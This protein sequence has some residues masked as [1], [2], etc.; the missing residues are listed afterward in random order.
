MRFK[1]KILIV[2][3]L[4]FLS[5][6]APA[7]KRVEASLSATLVSKFMWRGVEDGNA[8]IQPE[9][10]VAWRGFYI[11]L[12]G[13]HGLMN[14]T[15]ENWAVNELDVNIGWEYKGLT[16]GL[17]DEFITW[18][19]SPPKYFYFKQGGN[20]VLEATI[21]YDWGF[22]AAQWYTNIS[23][24]PECYEDE[25]GRLRHAY[26]SYLE[27]SAPFRLGGLDW[28]ALVGIVPYN[29]HD[30]YEGANSFCVNQLSLKVSKD[31]SVSKSFQLPIFGQL[32]VNPVL[33]QVNFVLG[34]SFGI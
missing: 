31:L 27:L 3:I 18:G 26:A 7:Q 24:T 9:L 13:S 17:G 23:G 22:F 33:N 8:A 4:S 29:S 2:C 34:L 1:A 25:K 16:I 30:W 20:H 19:T 6:A 15:G 21:G 10:N 28:E 32:V 11:N 5:S 12:W 14:N